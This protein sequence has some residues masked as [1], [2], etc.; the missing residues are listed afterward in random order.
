MGNFF[1]KLH[2]SSRR[3]P[4]PARRPRSHPTRCAPTSG[5]DHPAAP[6]PPFHPLHSGLLNQGRVPLPPRFYIAPKR[7]YAI[8]QAHSSSLGVCPL[9]SWGNSLKK[10]VVPRAFGHPRGVKIPPPGCKWTLRLPLKQV[11]TSAKPVTC[12]HPPRPCPKETEPS[13]PGESRNG[14][15]KDEDNQNPHSISS[16]PSASRSLE[17]S[18]AITSSL[19]I[20]GHLKGTL[21]PKGP[22]NSLY[23]KT[24]VSSGS[25]F[26][27]DCAIAS[28]CSP[29]GGVLPH[30]KLIPDA[31]G[32][33]GLPKRL[34]KSTKKGLEEGHQPS[35]PASLGSGKEKQEEKHSHMPSGSNSPPTSACPRPHKRKLLLVPPPWD[36]GELL[37]PP[38]R[39][40]ILVAGDL[41]L[42]RT[43]EPQ[44]NH[45][46]LE[47][48]EEATS[49]CSTT[50][51]TSPSS[52][53]VA[54]TQ[55]SLS[56]TTSTLPVSTMSFTD[57]SSLSASPSTLCSPRPSPAPEIGLEEKC[58]M[59]STPSLSIPAK[60]ASSFTFSPIFRGKLSNED[61]GSLCFY[62]LVPDAAPSPSD[63]S[64][65]PS[66]SAVSF[67]PTSF[68]EESPVPML[69]DSPS[70]FSPT[71]LPP[72]PIPS[73]STLMFTSQPI[74]FIAITPTI[75]A[76]A[77]ANSTSQ[78]VLDPDVR[79]MDTSPPSQ[80]VIFMSP[81]GSGVS[82]LPLAQ[83][84]GCGDQVSPAK[85]PVSTSPPVFTVSYPAA[86]FSLPFCPGVTPQPRPGT[87]GGHQQRATGLALTAPSAT[88][89]SL[90]S[91][92]A[93]SA[94]KPDCEGMDTTPPSL[95]VIFPFPAGTKDNSM[96]FPKAVLGGKSM[97]MSCSIVSTPGS[98]SLPAQ[99]VSSPTATFRHLLDPGTTPQPTFGSPDWQQPGP[100]TFH[101][102]IPVG[103]WAV[104]TQAENRTVTV[105][106]PPNN[107]TNQSTFVGLAPTYSTSNNHA[108]TQFGFDGTPGVV[109]ISIATSSGFKTTT[110]IPSAGKSK[111]LFANST[112]DPPV[113]M[114]SATPMG[115]GNFGV[116][117]PAP[118]PSSMTGALNSGAG[119]SGT[120]NTSSIPPIGP[121]TWDQ[122]GSTLPVFVN[123]MGGTFIQSTWG[124]PVQS[125][126]DA[127]GNGPKPVTPARPV[128]AFHQR[129][130]ATPHQ[131]KHALSGE[132]NTSRRKYPQKYN[133][134]PVFHQSTLGTFG[135]GTSAGD[136]GASNI[137]VLGH[138]GAPSYSQNPWGTPLRSRVGMKR[139]DSTIPMVGC[140]CVPH[141]HQCSY[142]LHGQSMYGATGE[143]CTMP[144]DGAL[145]DPSF[146][147][148]TWSSPGQSTHDV[149]GGNSTI[150]VNG[151]PHASHF[152]QSN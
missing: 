73:T 95:A 71:S 31:G 52:L 108:S 21:H 146:H 149:M 119:P 86:S 110:S 131:S 80:A 122:V 100:S 117:A 111:S 84:H 152:Y 39:P 79:D 103:Q 27:K 148:Y 19:H 125:T 101:R 54:P 33:S 115:S 144:T 17:T 134:A 69:V 53:S 72:P 88:S 37:P 129:A 46:A 96:P 121:N 63:I 128:L 116:N 92:S 126:D 4:P 98:T 43:A 104:P 16:A 50:Q 6:A 147:Q 82:S 127:M 58:Q 66:T 81:P 83:A 22:E 44:G 123:T 25:S 106:R 120:L 78:P 140:P 85:A 2:P 124:P 29:A 94:I 38:K 141:F 145:W 18:G 77:S 42:E 20:S 118:G 61:G 74:K 8:R 55:D 138:T 137:T 13:A 105:A 133:Y 60:S 24:Q 5:R 23:N 65:P 113:F 14:T 3:Y 67:H 107:N 57:L 12:S 49:D 7:R 56:C 76:T 114:R 68:R 142:S 75:T 87:P 135:D 41:G 30:Q 9:M 143:N 15:E 130:W 112:R 102:S 35:S 51:T 97:L 89:T 99:S 34:M 36:Q 150:P 59:P 62:P 1:S 10:Q 70:F 151:G 48:K 91:T 40:R 26:T 64:T 11:V 93:D 90:G 109:P 32:L 132:A 139:R 136:S 47:D 28:S 45:T